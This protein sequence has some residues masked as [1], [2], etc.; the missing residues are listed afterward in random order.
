MS[1]GTCSHSPSARAFEDYINNGGGY[2]GI[3][4]SAGDFIYFWDWYVDTLIGARFIG[5]AMDPQF[6]DAR[7]NIETN[8]SGIGKGLGSGWTMNDEWYSFKASPRDSGATVIATLD[9]STYSPVGRGGQDVRMGD[10]H[11][12]AWSRCLGKGRAFYS[13][14]GHRPE[15]YSEPNHLQLLQDAI[16]WTT[17]QVNTSCNADNE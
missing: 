10:D 5:H 17:G 4:G 3:H 16:L 13:G 12:I 7:V 8:S 15:V 14:I 11:P 1:A 6:Q 2:V 9:E